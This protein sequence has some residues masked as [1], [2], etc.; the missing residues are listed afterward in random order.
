[1]NRDN[2]ADIVL[3]TGAGTRGNIRVISG[4]DNSQLVNFPAFSAAFNGGAFV[5]LTDGNNDGVLDIAVTPGFGRPADVMLFD[6]VTG[7]FT[8]YSAFAGYL[9]G[10]TVGGARG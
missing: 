6:F 8:T 5:A 2:V 10:A 7:Q 1:V 3:S 4:V 9:G